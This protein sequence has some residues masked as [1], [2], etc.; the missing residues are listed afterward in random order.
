LVVVGQTDGI[1]R[2]VELASGR[3][4]AG[5]IH[6]DL[7]PANILLQRKSTTDN[8]ENT[9]NRATYHFSSV[10]SDL[11][12]LSCVPKIADFGLAK[13]ERAELTATGD[14]LGTPSYMA[15]EQAC[16]DGTSLGPAVDTYALGALLY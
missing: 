11:P 2:H 5:V 13:H 4:D 16:G 7:K 3:D 8:M 1:Y 14:I 15:P 6:R 12:V 10:P 9:D